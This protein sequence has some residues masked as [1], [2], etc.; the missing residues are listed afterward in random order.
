MNRTKLQTPIELFFWLL[1]VAVAWQAVRFCQ[2]LA[3]IP[4]LDKPVP[5]GLLA[6]IVQVPIYYM[7]GVMIWLTAAL[8][9]MYGG[10]AIA[11]IV[12]VGHNRFA[13][14]F[15]T[16]WEEDRR[17]AQMYS[18]RKKRREMRRKLRQE[19]SGGGSGT[20]LIIGAILGGIFF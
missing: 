15:K 17:I 6:W 2:G 11:R 8:F 3:P 18:D 1:G 14:E 9:V 20:A 19:K 4:F 16:S 10:R 12:A 13:V 7:V 5:G